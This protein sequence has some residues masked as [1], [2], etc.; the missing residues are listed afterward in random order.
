MLPAIILAGALAVPFAELESQEPVS[1]WALD[2]G[3]LRP[4]AKNLV[5]VGRIPSQRLPQD[6]LCVEAICASDATDPW[7]GVLGAVED[8]GSY[9]RGWVLGSH[10]DHFFFG[11]TGAATKRIHYIQ[12]RIRHQPGTWHQVVGTYDGKVQRL[13]VDGVLDTEAEVTSGPLYY[14]E[15]HHLTLGSYE[16]SNERH[17]FVGAIHSVHLWGHVPLPAEMVRRWEGVK[18]DLVDRRNGFPEESRTGWSTYGADPRRSHAVDMDWDARPK[19][20]WTHSPSQAPVP[21]WG[22]PADGSHWQNL[23]SLTSRVIHDRAFFPVSR[24]GRVFYGSSADDGVHALDANTGRRLWSFYSEGPVRFAPSVGDGRLWFGSDDG[25]VYCLAAE[26]GELIWRQQLAPNNRRIPSN[27]K[28]IS[29]WPVRTGV[30]VA[31]GILY[32]TAGLFPEQGCFAWALDAETGETHWKKTLEKSVSPQGYLLVSPTRLYIPNGRSTPFALD[33]TDGGWRGSFGGPGGSWALLTETELITGPDDRGKLAVASSSGMDNLASFPGRNIV[34]SQGISFLQTDTALLAVDRERHNQLSAKRD[35]LA[36]TKPTIPTGATLDE[37][38][39]LE[40]Q[41]G[42]IDE[43]LTELDRLLATCMVWSVSE[44]LSLALIVLGDQVILGGQGWVRSR[45]RG[46]GE[47]RW[48]IPVPGAVQGLAFS[49][50]NLYV[51][52]DDGQLCCIAEREVVSTAPSAAPAPSIQRDND[53]PLPK[54]MHGRKGYGLIVEPTGV[55]AIEAV[56][57]NT[58]LSLVIRVADREAAAR[59]R[60]SVASMH[61]LQVFVGEGRGITDYC[62]ELVIDANSADFS[63]YEPLLRPGRGVALLE[64]DLHMRPGLE[65]A[66]EWSHA[67]A[68][69]GNTAT[70]MDQ[71]VAD[72]LVLQWFGGPGPAGVVDRH[73]RSAPPLCVEGVL[74]IPGQDRLRAVDAYH[75]VLLW[76][77]AF[78]G[79]SRMAVPLDGG[80][81]AADA[82]ELWIAQGSLLRCI[83]LHGGEDLRSMAAPKGL[84]FGWLALDAET[85]VVS[86]QAVG[87]S[88]REQTRQEVS[89]QY[90]DAQ[91]LVCSQALMAFHRK[92]GRLE[93][94]HDMTCVPNASLA[95]SEGRVF[96][97][98]ARQV[99][100]SG[101]VLPSAIAQ[102]DPVLFAIELERGVKLYS[103]PIELDGMQHSLFVSVRADDLVL[104][105]SHTHSGGKSGF[106][107]QVRHARDGELRWKAST[108]NN[109]AGNGHGEQVHHPVLFPDVL[110]AEPR[111]FDLKS[112]AV[113]NDGQ[114]WMGKRRGCGTLSAS[115]NTLYFRDQNP[116][117]RRLDG[118]DVHL[119]SISRPGCWINI[120]PAAGLVL[121]PEASAGCV[122]SFPVQTSMA[123]LPR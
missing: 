2:E 89:L 95:L 27:G 81:Q 87:S 64:G 115:A 121:L 31:N 74:V 34:V 94:S 71:H 88:R 96:G 75:G 19:L 116:R 37:S 18:P 15:E 45:E 113:L 54:Q 120:L 23:N 69:A 61:R 32:A 8:N 123:F 66:G 10:G 30:A 118:K 84:E 17:E 103:R 76:D 98:D 3:Q 79:L 47:E 77:R 93:W 38:R 49:D 5:E 57:D 108:P 72:D 104:T 83:D 36:K 53:Y 52:L 42:A 97:V 56:L 40:E 65:G 25:C 86:V 90:K 51:A 29:P 21:S 50:G 91:A 43:A 82:G 13:Y 67:F 59:V 55:N 109:G 73:L 41:V 35:E 46:T 24:D 1:V 100:Q 85:V 12:G 39:A 119:T 60:S 16:D 107:M 9:E 70:S 80:Y 99:T 14:A 33:R 117:A 58:E 111:A 105:T 92:S 110:V 20:V 114:W 101:R 7:C 63:L 68:D 106:A 44:E 22:A 122:C 4:S 6:A 78:D 26:T 48:R 62:M 11:V 28:L 112:G 102:S